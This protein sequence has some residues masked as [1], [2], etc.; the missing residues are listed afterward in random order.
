MTS[1][2]HHFLE[3]VRSTLRAWMAGSRGP[4]AASSEE[5][6]EL[7]LPR[8]AVRDA[9]TALDEVDPCSIFEHR[10]SVMKE[11][12]NSSVDRSGTHSK[13]ALE[14]ATARSSS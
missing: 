6:L 10:A 12:H 3:T 13:L 8:G 1:P 5:D 11:F 4:C 7:P 2:L 9:L 14:E